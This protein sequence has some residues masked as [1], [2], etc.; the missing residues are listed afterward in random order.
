MYIPSAAL[1]LLL[2]STL[3]SAADSSKNPPK[4]C[5]LHSPTS[6]SYFDLTP[7]S[8]EPP[9]KDAKTR[10]KSHKDAREES[11]HAKG[12]DY[13]A[14]FTINFCAP[15]IED[16]AE[17]GG[18]EGVDKKL[19][20]NVSAYYE[21]KGEIYS[22]GYVIRSPEAEVIS[23]QASLTLRVEF[24]LFFDARHT[25]DTTPFSTANIPPSPSSVAASSS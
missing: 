7:I 1:L 16:L 17:M 6:G 15:V 20:A 23:L 9:E 14:N 10:K 8:L 25:T 2:L 4:P 21:Y 11:W 12:Y 18:V 19:W 22:I 24:D 5:T 13:P 3:T